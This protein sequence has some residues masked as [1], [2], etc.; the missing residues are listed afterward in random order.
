MSS[1]TSSVS[2]SNTTGI[3]LMC[4]AMG[5]GAG[6]DVIV[7]LL[8][9]S[10]T[11]PQILTLRGVFVCVVSLIWVIAAGY[12]RSLVQ[13]KNPLVMLRSALE[14]VSSISFFL[15]LANMPIAELS[16]V[17]LVTPLLIAAGAGLFY[18]EKITLGGWG[19]IIAGFIGMLLVVKPGTDNFTSF[20][21]YGIASAV[22][23]A[24]RDLLTRKIKSDVSSLV[25]CFS[26]GVANM[27]L[28]VFMTMAQWS[29]SPLKAATL[30]SPTLWLGLLL[31]AIVVTLA[32]YGVILAFRQ[33]KASVISPF[34]YSA[35]L[36]A[37]LAG[38]IIWH[39]APDSIALF[40]SAIIMA[41][42][43]YVLRSERKERRKYNPASALEA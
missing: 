6:N 26:A 12:G 23:T 41:S 24:S 27:L 8:S 43:L 29:Q 34:R 4:V 39:E 18:S 11:V 36:W 10:L 9:D 37:M 13:M 25:V 20:A 5:L 7:K 38:L 31:A 42:G 16:A 14:A 32:N 33:S 40:G 21:F 30:L 3:V 2:P 15:A 28:G 22:A 19:A 35:L 17:F 1:S